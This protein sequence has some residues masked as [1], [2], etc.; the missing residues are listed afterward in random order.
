MIS[1]AFRKLSA[2]PMH[3][4][5]IL[6]FTFCSAMLLGSSA[7]AQTP[8][9]K[10][11][12]QVKTDTRKGVVAMRF[13]VPEGWHCFS[14]TQPPG[15]PMKSKISI[16]GKGVKVTGDFV[17]LAPPE[18]HVSDVFGI[19]CEE[20]QGDVVWEAPVEFDAGIDPAKVALTVK[21]KGQIC[22][23][24]PPGS[25]KQVNEKV[26]ASFN[27]FV[28]DLTMGGKMAEEKKATPK[29]LELKPYQP[30]KA[31]VT[32]TGS[33]WTDDGTQNFKPG[34]EV[35]L[36]ITAVPLEGYHFYA[37][38]TL[39]P[40]D[41]MPTLISL[42]RPEGW[43]ITGPQ[44]SVDPVDHDGSFEHD[45]ATTWTFKVKIPSD[46]A[47]DQ[48]VAITG[49]VQVLTCKEACDRPSDSHF[50]VTV[51][52]GTDS[53]TALNFAP[54]KMGSVANA[55]KAGDFADRKVSTPMSSEKKTKEK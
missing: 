9:V 50:T 54:A 35:T 7:F 36:E 52:M 18:S 21:Y 20:H 3:L 45:E 44:V 48:A 5:R 22:M 55:V 11:D 40:R 23:N 43:Q 4:A 26:A 51:P 12:F 15:G 6:C 13:T 49:G 25:C 31:H 33:M 10:S 39:E 2:Q 34:D 24:E 53:A 46:A 47:P 16:D 28:K 17:P 37:Y 30:E 8:L 38:E 41:Y 27:G 14:N 42:K 32:L 29:K 19:V 1:C